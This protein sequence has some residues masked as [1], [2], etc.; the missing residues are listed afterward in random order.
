MKSRFNLRV[1]RKVDGSDITR[2]GSEENP[3]CY[4]DGDDGGSVLKL[5]SE[6][7]SAYG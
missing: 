6:L 1:A 4:V 2:D 7:E 5:K 3:A